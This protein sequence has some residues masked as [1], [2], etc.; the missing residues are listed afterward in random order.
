MKAPSESEPTSILGKSVEGN[1]TFAVRNLTGEKHSEFGVSSG[2]APDAFF[3][4][5]TRSWEVGF[6]LTVRR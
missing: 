6:M 3:P 2:F 4:A 1:L 5:A